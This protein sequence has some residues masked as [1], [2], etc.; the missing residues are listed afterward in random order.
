VVIGGG[1]LGLEAAAGL[2]A[3]GMEVTVLH[4]MPT[5]MERQLDPAAGYLLQKAMEQRGIKVIT[6]A[7]TK[8]ILGDA[9]SRAS[10]RRRQV[11]RPTL[12]VMAVGIRPNAALAKEAGL[13]STAASSST[14]ACDSDP[15]IY[16]VGECA[17]HRRQCLRPGRAAL[18]DGPRRW[19]RASRRRRR[20]YHGST[21]RPS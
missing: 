17:E 14:T 18:R 19:P 6:R 12:V 1:L 13:R 20:R 8:A 2:R 3:R 21:R 4:L 5:L 11:S 9:G 7:N 16:A 15:D 10:P